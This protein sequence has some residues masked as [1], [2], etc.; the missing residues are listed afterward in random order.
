MRMRDNVA[1]TPTDT[2]RKED[3]V[4][5]EEQFRK[6]RAIR[7]NIVGERIAAALDKLPQGD[8]RQVF[9]DLVDQFCFGLVWTRDGLPVK[10]RSMITVAM[11]AALGRKEEF[12]IHVRGALANGCTPQ[13]IYE[14]VLH[15]SVYA[16]IPA[17]AA[18]LRWA[19]GVLEADRK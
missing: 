15:S 8:V 17:G 3:R 5:S 2:D 14:I 7:D 12:E 11:L 9:T 13:E 16:G 18:A 19:R 1:R 4:I 10:T 6:G